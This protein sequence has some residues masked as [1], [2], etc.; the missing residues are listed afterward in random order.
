MEKIKPISTKD[1]ELYKKSESGDS[2]EGLLMPLS[3]HLEDLR[4]K[5]I[6]SVFFVSIT[7]VIGFTLSKEIIRLLINIAP[8]DT[9]FLQI[10]PGEFFFTTLRVALYFGIST[11]SPIIIWQLGNFILPGLKTQEKKAI[12]PIL[13]SSPI[14]FFSGILFSYFFV[15]PSMFKFLFNFGQGIISTSIS[16]E[17]FISFTLMILSVCGFIFLIPVV[18]FALAIAGIITSA[19]L[20]KKWRYAILG[21]FIAGAIFTPTP[22]PFNMG[23]VS[24]ILIALYFISVIAL[25]IA[26][27]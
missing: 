13:I 23:I 12:F 6:V 17:S 2:E 4:N 11:A 27:L 24:G 18:F 22:D 16:I 26:R 25:K 15:A 3:K 7:T 14:L 19:T 20:L 21:S 1:L 8:N 5:I 10:K 9:T